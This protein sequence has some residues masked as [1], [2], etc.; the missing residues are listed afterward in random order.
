MLGEIDSIV[1]RH[2]K[3]VGKFKKNS[4]ISQ[5]LSDDDKAAINQLYS[6]KING[7]IGDIRNAIID[8]I[9]GFNGDDDDEEVKEDFATYLRRFEENGG[10]DNAV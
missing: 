1:A 4:A 6:A 8:E 9:N 10:E 2:N 3:D 5:R 7:I